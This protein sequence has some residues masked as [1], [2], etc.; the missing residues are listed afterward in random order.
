MNLKQVIILFF[1]LGYCHFSPVGGQEKS[2]PEIFG[3]DWRNA[4]TWLS[5]N[6]SWIKP[7]LDKYDLDYFETVAVVFPE[8]VRYSSIM[9]RMETALLKTLYVNAGKDYAN[10]SIGRFQVKP[11]FAESVGAKAKN[12]LSHRYSSI[13]RDSSAY[14]DISDYRSDIVQDLE[15][16]RTELN[17][18]IVF[19]KICSRR[20]NISRMEA[21]ERVRFLSAAYNGGFFKPEKDIRQMEE[22]KFFGTGLIKKELYSYSD[23]SVYW[24]RMHSG[25]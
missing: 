7:V 14:R 15:N 12:M 6:D 11:S 8:L 18:L 19:M 24:Y 20:F 23:I 22:R 5:E 4:E 17:Y 21:V 3:E 2:Y 1:L 16:S 25:K 9:D 10:F 13:V